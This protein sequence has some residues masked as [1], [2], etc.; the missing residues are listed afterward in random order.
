M[1]NLG[2]RAYRVAPDFAVRPF[3]NGHLD[4]G[5]LVEDDKMFVPINKGASN[6][7]NTKLKKSSSIDARIFAKICDHRYGGDA[8]LERQ[9][10]N[11]Y[12]IGKLETRY[13]YPQL[14]YIKH[15]LRLEAVREYNEMTEY[16]KPVYLVTGLKIA[17]GVTISKEDDRN[18]FCKFFGKAS[19]PEESADFV[20]AIQVLKIHHKRRPLGH[21]SYHLATAF[22]PVL[23]ENEDFTIA[24]LDNEVEGLVPC[25]GSTINGEDETWLLAADAV[26]ENHK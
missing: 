20:L 11:V 17:W 9:T 7:I 14:D 13:F 10:K 12:T 15:C 1:M 8:S 16:K 26:P 6:R 25:T 21:C 23:R 4:L 22:R 3:S 5:T 18:F 19:S 2:S 24:E